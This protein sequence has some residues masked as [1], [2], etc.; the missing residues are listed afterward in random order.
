MKSLLLLSVLLLSAGT[1]KAEGMDAKNAYY[2]GIV[3]GAGMILCETINMGELKKDSAKEALGN[4]VEQL[5]SA[6]GNSDV[7]DSIQIAYQAVKQEGNCKG[8]Y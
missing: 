1:A 4:F 6:P 7:A 2:S 3:F 8:V 5:S